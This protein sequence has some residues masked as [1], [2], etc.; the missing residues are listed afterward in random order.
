MMIEIKKA[1]SAFYN[2]FV[3]HFNSSYDDVIYFQFFLNL[4]FELKK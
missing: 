3:R 1:H 2:S 4:K